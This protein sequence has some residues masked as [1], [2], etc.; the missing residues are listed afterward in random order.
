MNWSE[1]RKKF[2]EKKNKLDAQQTTLNQTIQQLNKQVADFIQRGGLSQDPASNPQYTSILQSLNR[3]ENTKTQYNEI[4]QQILKYLKD[5]STTTKWEEKLKQNGEMQQ[6]IIQLE[7]IQKEMKVDV[8]S[9]LARD[10]L[11]R[12]KDTRV[13]RQDLFLFNRPVSR[14]L[15]PYLWALSVVFIAVGLF[16]FKISFPVSMNIQN[17]SM[18]MPM[19]STF[20]TLLSEYFYNNMILISVVICALI[21]IIFLSLTVAGVFKS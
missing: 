5:N 8:D 20:I 16:V 14:S 3:I 19:T 15:V 2:V 9:A 6:E 17:T 18:G 10:E 21:V 13:S 1:E 4:N 12:T 11:L 7:R